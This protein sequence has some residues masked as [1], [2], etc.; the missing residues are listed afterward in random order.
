MLK[1]VP[2]SNKV[3]TTWKAALGRRGGT[4]R[5]LRKTSFLEKPAT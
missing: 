4:L 3:P 1:Y 5:L 2:D